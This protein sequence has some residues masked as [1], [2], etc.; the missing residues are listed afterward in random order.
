M[1]TSHKLTQVLLAL[2]ALAVLASASLAQTPV[3]PGTPYPKDDV[4]SDQKAGSVLIYNLY[5]SSAAN[6]NATNTRINITNT[7]SNFSIAVHLFFLD[8]GSCTPADVYVCLTPNQTAS[9]L[10][11]DVDPG[12]TGYIVAV[13]SDQRFGCPVKFNHLIGDGYVKLSTGHVANLAAESVA[14]I[15]DLPIACGVEGGTATIYFDNWMYDWVGR[16]LAVDNIPS[17]VDGN[18]TLLV[19][20]RIGGDLATGAGNIGLLFGILY[21]D[22]ETP[23][24][25]TLSAGCQL[26]VAI[27]NA[28][29]RVLGGGVS[30][31]IP[32]GRSGWL[33]VWSTSADDAFSSGGRGVLGAV[34]NANANTLTSASAFNGGHNLHKLTVSIIDSFV[35]PIFPPAC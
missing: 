11:S 23:F 17:P 2:V 13:A 21:D 10:A 20:N 18:N 3:G 1:R 5:S 33:K 16:T 29:F 30:G 35:I 25:F 24:S 31:V 32:S 4:V 27:N 22:A 8:G 34:L 7:S 19:I 28:N 12:V 26:R 14:A 6:P 9:F 15:T